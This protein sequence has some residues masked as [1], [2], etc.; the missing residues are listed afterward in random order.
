MYI[1]EKTTA[2]V[3]NSDG[4]SYLRIVETVNGDKVASRF[5]HDILLLD[6]T[7]DG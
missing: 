6:V 1:L 4:D 2:D 3:T 7:G 5:G